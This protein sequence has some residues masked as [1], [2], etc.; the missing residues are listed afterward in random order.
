[1]SVSL[2]EI[3]PENFKEC[4]TLKVA[5]GQ[6]NFVCPNV[7]SIAHSKVYPTVEPYAVYDDERMV[8][9][10]MLGFISHL[11]RYYLVRLMIDENFQGKGFG[12]AAALAVIER[13]KQIEEC[14]EIY[15]NF[16]PENKNAEKLYQSVG[17]ERTGELNEGEIVMR[18]LIENNANPKSKIQNKTDVS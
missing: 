15:L 1:M 5:D 9:F 10:V 12:R 16:V 11:K 14:R 18:Y 6:T 17:F 7:T 8:G 13:M 3:T 4:I 2:R